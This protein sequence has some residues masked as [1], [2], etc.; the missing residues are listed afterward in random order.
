M[1]ATFWDELFVDR[2]VN[3][4]T[5]PSCLDNRAWDLSWGQ[6]VADELFKGL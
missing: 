6:G 4:Q 5:H 1:V 3:K 2:S